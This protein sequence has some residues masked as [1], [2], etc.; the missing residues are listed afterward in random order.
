MHAMGGVLAIGPTFPKQW[1]HDTTP[2]GA[3]TTVVRLLLFLNK[4]AEPA[5]T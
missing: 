1:E 2:V 5:G 3:P 4:K